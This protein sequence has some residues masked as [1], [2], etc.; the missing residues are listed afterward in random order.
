MIGKQ[1]GAAAARRPLIVRLAVMAAFLSVAG[2]A[3]AD[4]DDIVNANGF[5][6]PFSILAGG[7]TG[8]LEGQ[9]NPPG[10]GQVL[11]PGQWQRTPGGTSSA[12]VQTAMVASGLQAVQ[13]DRVAN[14]DARWAVQVDHLGYP[15][16]PSPFP[17]EPAQPCICINWDMKVNQQTA[18]PN[19]FGPFFGVEAY[20]DSGTIGLLG[21]LGVDATTGDVLYQATGTGVLTETNSVVN[22]GQWNRFQIKLDYATDQYTIYRNF[23][24]LGTFGFVDPGLEQFSDADISAIAAGGDAASQAAVGRAFFDNF[25]VR[26]GGCPIPEPGTFVLVGLALGGASLAARRSRRGQL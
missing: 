23:Q 22:F 4:D 12:V 19:A 21:S 15:D 1:L 16:Y 10:E 8:R 24:S 13:V 7:G 20:D 2:T 25:L 18:N 3:F 17:P 26:E 11:P 14:N 9:V 5:E 6:L